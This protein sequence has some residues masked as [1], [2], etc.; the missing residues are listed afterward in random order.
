MLNS[1][2]ESLAAETFPDSVRTN[3]RLL[4]RTKR[5]QTPS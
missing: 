1:P 3:R 2:F 5:H 4:A